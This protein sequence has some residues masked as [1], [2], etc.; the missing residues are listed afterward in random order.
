[1]PAKKIPIGQKRIQRGFTI[2]PKTS[3]LISQI[4]IVND[5]AMNR[6]IDLV[7]RE[8]AVRHGIKAS[9]EFTESTLSQEQIAAIKAKNV[10]EQ[11]RSQRSYK[12]RTI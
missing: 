2:S 8:Y 9:G 6:V 10:L 12:K 5:I 3:D 4:A 11:N 1:M 7:V